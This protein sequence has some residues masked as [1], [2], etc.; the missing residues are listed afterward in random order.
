LATG[1][2]AYTIY[3]NSTGAVTVTSP[4]TVIDKDKTYGTITWV[5]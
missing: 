1:T 2:E 4:P 3:N 5:E